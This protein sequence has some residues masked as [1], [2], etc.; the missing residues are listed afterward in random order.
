MTVFQFFQTVIKEYKLTFFI[1]C[2]CL[3]IASV[4]EL[5]SLAALVPLIANIVDS[6]TLLDGNIKTVMEILGLSGF[7]SSLLLGIVVGFMLLRT[8]LLFISYNISGRMSAAIER[9]MR[10]SL[11]RSV[12]YANWSF[13]T[14]QESGNLTNIMTMEAGRAGL[15]AQFLSKFLVFSALSFV[16][17]IAAFLISWKAFLAAVF[18][19]LP[20]MFL[21]N[22]LHKKTK[23]QAKER[24][25]AS[26]A[27]SSSILEMFSQAK[28]TKAGHFESHAIKR[29]Q[30]I[31]DRIEGLQIKDVLYQSTVTVLP[32][33]LMVIILA[34]LIVVISVF[35]LT[36]TGDFVFFLLVMFRCQRFLGQMQ[37]MQQKLNAHLPSFE[38]CEDL[39]KQANTEQE[40]IFSSDYTA[41]DIAFNKAIRFE[42]LHF[43]YQNQGDLF[44]SISLEIPKNS[45]VAFVGRS[46]AGKTTLIDLLTGLLKPDSGQITID[47]Q[48]LKEDH[49]QK[50]RQKIFYVSQDPAPFNGTIYENITRDL[51]PV[52]DEVLQTILDK[53]MVSE[54]V[55]T[56][57]E[58]LNTKI[59]DRGV[60]LSGGQKQRIALA[61]AL[62]SK[63]EILILDEATSALDNQSEEEIRQTIS[64]LHGDITIILIA[65]RLSTV[66]DAD[67]IFV[68][69]D[70]KIA[71]Q[72]SYEQLIEQEG[73]FSALVNAEKAR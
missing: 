5:V 13:L 72:G 39:M 20:L 24:V 15:A 63:P 56:R 51:D 17:L 67:T 57:P 49:L 48:T 23:A 18:F 69:D 33:A 59:G 61:R 45:I 29:L 71:E 27:C 35:D 8:M 25:K 70:G 6:E 73:V 53:T 12:L 36:S 64:A 28:Q 50:W 34:A 31:I 58:G 30:T 43:S 40:P 44:S 11:F 37:N 47:G 68:V 46:G 62:L 22:M 4:L 60:Q 52:D 7:S 10:Y 66:Q 9:H 55:K 65:H 32:D 54:F 16:F 21:A 1:V 14:A 3:L 41:Q 19:S 38:A 2:L 26:N 42:D